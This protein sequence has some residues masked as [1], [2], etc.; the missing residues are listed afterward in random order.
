MTIA[1]GITEFS[2]VEWTAW[3]HGIV[4]MYVFAIIL[5]AL[6]VAW[7][8]AVLGR[9]MKATERRKQLKWDKQLTDFK[10]RNE[11]LNLSV[12]S[13]G[14]NVTAT[15]RIAKCSISGTSQIQKGE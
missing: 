6:L 14:S 4:K 2:K 9:E 15:K 11:F 13:Q 1:E 10:M 12:N 7:I 3:T 8:S 5:V